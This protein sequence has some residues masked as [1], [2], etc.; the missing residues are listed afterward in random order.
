MAKFK[1]HQPLRKPQKDDG[2]PKAL[3]I[4]GISLGVV[5]IALIALVVFVNN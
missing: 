4:V 5:V 1:T 3:K 2:N